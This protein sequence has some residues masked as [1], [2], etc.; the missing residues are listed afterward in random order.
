V[1]AKNLKRSFS[2]R[3]LL[4]WGGFGVHQNVDRWTGQ[5]EIDMQVPTGSKSFNVLEKR[6]SSTSPETRH[7]YGTASKEAHN[8]QGSRLVCADSAVGAD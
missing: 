3:R 1:F 8:L 5:T 2:S 4:A 6:R 7:T